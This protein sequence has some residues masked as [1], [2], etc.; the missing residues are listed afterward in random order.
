MTIPT[1]NLLSTICLIVAAVLCVI[2]IILFFAFRI[3]YCIGVLAGIGVK[4]EIQRLT[5]YTEVA[6]PFT[7]NEVTQELEQPFVD[8]N[9]TTILSSNQD[10]QKIVIYD[11]ISTIVTDAQEIIPL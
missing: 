9:V 3:K 1:L 11:D 4:K 2:A 5:E 6:S 10:Y 8:Q 7:N